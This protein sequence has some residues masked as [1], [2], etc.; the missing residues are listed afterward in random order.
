MNYLVH[1][2]WNDWTIGQ[3]SVTC[4]N[5]TRTNTRTQKQPAQFGGDECIGSESA[6]VNCNDLEC[7][8]RIFPKIPNLVSFAMTLNSIKYCNFIV[9]SFFL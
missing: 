1:C 6:V 5:G 2:V 4:G 7:P 9:K 8:G 3:C